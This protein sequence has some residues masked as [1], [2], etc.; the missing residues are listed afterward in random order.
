MPEAARYQRMK[1]A[2]R[3]ERPPP[4]FDVHWKG[5][6]SKDAGITWVLPEN[7]R[8]DYFAWYNA[9]FVNDDNFGATVYKLGA[10]HEEWCALLETAYRDVFL[11]PRD[12]Y[13]TWLLNIGYITYLIL[14]KKDTIAAKGILNVSWSKDLAEETYAAVR[15]NL[16]ENP[17]ILNFYGYVIDEDRSLTQT[18]MY[19][20]YQPEG[21]KPGFFCTS[22]AGGRITG[23]HP[24]YAFLDDIQQ[25]ALTPEIM[26]KVRNIIKQRL[27]PALGPNG[28]LI[29][30]G[31]IKGWNAKNDV[32]LWLED[33][34]IFNIHRYPAADSMPP[35]EHITAETTIV[36]V[37][38]QYTGKPKMRANGEPLTRKSYHI[39][40]IR[41]RGLYHTIY[42]ERYQIEDLV[43]KRLELRDEKGN[44]DVF[45]S[46]YFLQASNPAGKYLSRTRL[47]YQPPDGFTSYHS[48]AD[49][50][51]RMHIP[52]CAW[53][54]P[55]GATGH[56]IAIAVMAFFHGQCIV[57]DLVVSRSGIPG[58]ADAL[59]DL[60]IRWH[61]SRWGVE[62]NFQQKE[63]FGYALARELMRALRD[64]GRA[65]MYT[66]PLIKQNSGD[67]M[68]RIATHVTAM[69]GP[70]GAPPAFIV[71]ML[72]TAIE[73]F[74]T[75]YTM[76]GP[77]VPSLQAKHQFDLLD[78]VA[79]AKIHLASASRPFAAG[80]Y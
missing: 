38:N 7:A 40:N 31:T 5:E 21:A 10:I 53:L 48:F 58:T 54:D 15:Q 25:S 13:K 49:E 65:S 43:I 44:D 16:S 51:E 34:P 76:F 71:N 75:E 59:A 55:G 69:L 50:C 77:D 67:K 63:T 20:T 61:V 62:G 33:N 32:Y 70:D 9:F 73:Q 29:I 1:N 26:T 35:M 6:V 56:G 78:S 18:K 66:A 46:E 42:P 72:A 8:R 37:I 22:L 39:I 3:D 74:N 36:P 2:D 68:Q 17:R 11:C 30:T 28:V 14:E 41:N 19:F 45:F 47:F 52:V 27:L 24:I 60:I 79:S 23:T 12:H 57:L 4:K 80:A 64:R